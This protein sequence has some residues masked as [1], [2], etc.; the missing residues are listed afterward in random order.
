M[1]RRRKKSKAAAAAKAREKEHSPM[2]IEKSLPALPANAIPPNAFSNDRVDPDSDTATELSPRPRAAHARTGSSSRS[3]SRPA[4]SPER[5]A[6]GLGLP[7]ST[8]RNNRNPTMMSRADTGSA[9]DP[10]SFF[11]SVA[12]D[13]SPH[14]TPRSTS[15]NLSEISKSKEKDYFGVPKSTSFEKRTDSQHTTPHIAFQEKGRQASSSEYDTPPKLP[16]RR[17]S[18]SGRTDSSKRSPA[19]DDRSVK[20]ATRRQPA[21]EEFKLQ[22]APKSKKLSSRSSSQ[23]SG[24]PT[25]LSSNRMSNGTTRPAYGG[26][27]NTD[28]NATTSPS[29]SSQ[30]SRPLEEEDLLR[31]SM[32]SSSRTTSRPDKNITRKEISSGATR[33]GKYVS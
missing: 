12:L 27:P 22:E 13:P 10:N 1:A 15:D 2:V 25:E 31:A 16:V 26:L 4:R 11:I 23:S 32:D 14:P 6:E 20:S 30:E 24:L 28:A 19:I 21:D 18:K 9:E 5:K 3:S 33:N 8:H 17:H 29:R 7:A